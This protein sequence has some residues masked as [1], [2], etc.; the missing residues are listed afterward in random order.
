MKT[1]TVEEAQRNFVE[2]LR[3]ALANKPQ[4]VMLGNDGVVVLSAKEYAAMAFARDLI[5][6]VQ[7]SG[8]PPGVG[9]QPADVVGAEPEGP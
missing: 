6:F 9:R 2:I 4:R 7:R 8:S 3:R 5:A 1:W